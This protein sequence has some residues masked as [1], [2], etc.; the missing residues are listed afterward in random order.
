[1]KNY[2]TQNIGGQRLVMFADIKR[3]SNGNWPAILSQLGL[4]VQLNKHA[5]CPGC[6]GR[7]RFRF[8]DRDGDGT[9]I[10]SQGTGEIVAGDGFALLE[11]V[12]GWTPKQALEVVSEVLGMNP[13]PSKQRPSKV[14]P[15]PTKP[16]TGL[17]DYALQ[18]WSSAATCAT[19]HP[20]LQRKRIDW[21]AGARRGLVS[22]RVV[23][24]NADCV[25]VPIRD[26]STFEVVAIQA[27]NQD[28]KK[29]TFGNIKGH[30]FLC[31][32][33]LDR[34]LPWYVVEGW[35]DGI[36]MAFAVHEGNAFCA[37]AMGKQNMRA[38]A[39]GLASRYQPKK[40]LILEDAS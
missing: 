33:E 8:D 16:P 34:Q 37:A 40:I 30:A 17:S 19:G 26:V 11:H 18:I 38:V 20:Y 29:Q 31:G 4:D 6:G 3:A 27:I 21:A 32:N 13:T 28:G 35:A 10:C 25:I 22:G 12:N 39:E 9:F 15:V 36:A 1:M 7:D 14:L 24:R 23:G 5:P 2:N